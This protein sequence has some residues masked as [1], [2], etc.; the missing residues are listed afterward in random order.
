MATKLD[1]QDQLHDALFFIEALIS[2][3]MS[4]SSHE[5][6]GDEVVTLLIVIRDKVRAVEPLLS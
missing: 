6:S 2:L 4:N 3:G 1:S 5:I